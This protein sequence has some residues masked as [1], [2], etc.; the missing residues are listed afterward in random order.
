VD[1]KELG[2]RLERMAALLELKGE[3]P[4]KVRA[5]AN[6]ARLIPSLP[7]L[8][9]R[10]NA[11]TLTEVKGIGASLADI[12]TGLWTT[13]THPAAA[14]IENHFP[15][16]LLEL[17]DI[18]G[19]GPKRIKALHDELH[20][21][22]PEELKY[23]VYENRLLDLPGFGKK[24]QDRIGAELARLER[25]RGRLLLDTAIRQ[26]EA[27]RQ[28]IPT[29]LDAG[30][31]RRLMP[32]VSSL[33]FLA[34]PDLAAHSVITALPGFAWTHEEGLLRGRAEGSATETLIRM[35]RGNV[36]LDLFESTGSS[37]H[38]RQIRELGPLPADPR[39]EEEI[40]A[41]AGLPWIPPEMR[42]GRGEVDLAAAGGLADVVTYEDLRGCF[43]NHTTESDGASSLEEMRS[44]AA[45]LGWGF[46]G[47]ADHSQ[48][49]KYAR[50]LEP[51]RLL[52]QVERIRALNVSGAFSL[53]AGT[54]SDILPDGAVDYPDDVL[55][56]LDYTVASIHSSFQLDEQ[57]QT[58]R[59]CRA[60]SHP[61]VKIL[62]H[63]TGR[64][65]LGRDGYPVDMEAVME[66]ARQHGKAVE[67]NANPHRLD[68]D[69]TLLGRAQALGIPVCINP[70]AHEASH[71]TDVRY[72]VWAA[73]KGLLR[74]ENCMNTWTVERVAEFFG[75]N[76]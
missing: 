36:W 24:S 70:D 71:L 29:L 63:P 25:L 43:H 41:A 21:A 12:V 14:E 2:F 52:K 15:R 59:L 49:A 46:L 22:S 54:E 65:L 6:A 55:A 13:G 18:P 74:K 10:I 11:G 56:R 68:L 9:E 50:G 4:F 5:F 53:F 62:G 28:K 42:E 38:V 17:F 3:N 58:Q 39:S 35:S 64:L 61:A 60:L 45:A 19:L 31:L 72:G 57:K 8:E 47:I 30:E 32:V 33:E 34:P 76:R 37:E 40:Y 69:W 67:I 27:I 26:A 1:K 23:A 73:R 66:A 20:I 16:G 48:S 75:R 51:E 7:D 44:A